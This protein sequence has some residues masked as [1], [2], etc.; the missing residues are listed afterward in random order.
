M[1]VLI[2]IQAKARPGQGKAG[3]KLL[4]I[5][6]EYTG[7]ANLTCLIST[8]VFPLIAIIGGRHEPSGHTPISLATVVRM[9]PQK[10]DL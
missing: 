8:T 4:C 6:I 1:I 3:G 2:S 10:V 9:S 7:Y 5:T